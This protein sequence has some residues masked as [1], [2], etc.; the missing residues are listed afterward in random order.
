M[1]TTST[2]QNLELQVDTLSG[3]QPFFVHPF[4]VPNTLIVS[5]KGVPLDS[6][7]YHFDVRLRQLLIPS[8]TRVDSVVVT[9]RIWDFN[10]P[11]RYSRVLESP[12][13]IDS[14]PPVKV[15]PPSEESRPIQLRRSGSISRGILAGN[16]R[17]AS[18]ESGLRLQMSGQIA[19]DIYLRAALTDENTPILPEGNTQRLSEI[20]RVF[21]EIETPFSSAQLGDFQLQ[22]N[23]SVFAQLN[24]KIQGV[25]ITAPLPLKTLNGSLQAAAATSRGL[26]NTQDLQVRDGVQGPYRLQGNA[27]EQ[28]ILVIPGSES[29]Y[30]DGNLLQRGESKDYVIDYATGEITFTTN[31]QIKYHHRIAVEFQYRTTEFTRT[32]AATE[33][34]I[35]TADRNSGSPL[36]SLG[37]TFIREADGKTFDQ[38]FGL[39]DTDKEL[40][41][42]LGDRNAARSGATTVLYDPNAPWIHYTLR[43]TT[44]GSE[45]FQIYLPITESTTE[46]VFRVEFSW[47]GPGMG[48]YI[49]QGQ[50]T[51]G[52]AYSYRGPKQGDY[53]P[54]RILPKPTQQQMLNLRASFSPIRQIEMNGEWAHSFRDENRF[55]SFDSA[56]DLGFSY[57]VRLGLSELPI[58]VGT[59][60]VTLNRRHTGQNFATFDRTQPI[61][62]IRLWNLPRDR[63]LVAANDETIDEASIAWNFSKMS[64]ITGLLGQLK[65]PR[66]FNGNRGEVALILNEP[67]LP[68]INYRF[69]HITSDADSVA[70][71]WIRHV[72]QASQSIIPQRLK[73]NSRLIYSQR[74]QNIPQ[75]LRQDSHQHFGIV[76]QVELDFDR[77]TVSVE[78]D[79]RG[80]HFWTADYQLIPARR[81][82]T[83]SMN[84]NTDPQRLFQSEGRI[85]LQYTNYTEFFQTMQ[86]LSSERS[87]VA[88][89]SGRVQPWNRLL[90]L[91]WNYEALSEQTP[92]LQEIYIRTGP[93]LGEYV[94]EDFNGNGVVEIDEFIPEVTED[95]G[96]YARTLIPSDSLQ[97][98]TGLKANLNIQFDGGRRWRNPQNTWEKWFRQVSLRLRVDVQEKS[99]DPHPTNIYLLRQKWFRHPENSIR[100]TINLIHD[101]WLFRNHPRYGFHASWRQIR[102]TNVFAAATE[103][104]SI[105]EFRAQLRW[106][107]SDQWTL[108]TEGAISDKM[109][110]SSSF[111]S[112]EFN[113]QTQSIAQEVQ[114]S[115]TSNVRIS[116]GIDYSRKNAK[117]G[118]PTTIL[119]FPSQVSWNRAG[120]ASMSCRIEL[121]NV[122]LTQ[123]STSTGLAFFELTDGRGEGRSLLWNLNGWLQLT[124]V[125]RGTISYSGRNPQD[126]PQIHTV[127][128]KLSATF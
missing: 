75:G 85:G 31:R 1:C 102:S 64:S 125:L 33:T 96:E 19:P 84:Y 9:Y 36:A 50:T 99:K 35:S 105:D 104:R 30:L 89:W 86:G 71:R 73:L 110:T 121:S 43:D 115:I 57:H 109:N 114:V 40:L 127:R 56:D 58:G 70:G 61:E 12:P 42:G 116:T 112:R 118:E 90:R 20:D 67:K 15:R 39:T 23:R 124:S 65:Q 63:G 80:E 48:D 4:S 117:S 41:S 22:L 3:V 14:I 122:S 94:W 5:I 34:T 82:A 128:M 54:I 68:F 62:F 95:E 72:A 107:P 77:G 38:E 47:V 11:K 16:N 17:D 27:N 49:R 21:I 120:R 7:E 45:S 106:G 55:S 60:E 44:I 78:F 91:N 113:I 6:S 10:L 2:A 119:K 76:P 8:I 123:E 53:L 37:V 79:W 103:S 69:I 108:R 18:I 98:V 100:G 24:R 52:I 28:F 74:L 111:T 32:L 46:E 26:F 25:G 81:T 83:Y 92:V 29:V 66:V 13:P 59:T 88:Q 51:N 126:A 101:L 93:E 87:L 97:A